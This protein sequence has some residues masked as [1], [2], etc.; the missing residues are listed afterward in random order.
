MVWAGISKKGAT[1]ITLLNCSVNSTVYHAS[2][3]PP[4]FPPGATAQWT[5]AARQCAES[6]LQGNSEI[7]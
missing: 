5:V 3:T 2:H 1:N 4:T 7:S 6:R